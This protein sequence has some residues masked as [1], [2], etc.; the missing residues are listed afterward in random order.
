[1]QV[2][3]IVD[4]LLVPSNIQVSY[5][6]FGSVI[7]IFQI[8]PDIRLSGL[9][10]YI[11]EIIRINPDNIRISVNISMLYKSRYRYSRYKLSASHYI[12]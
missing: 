11:S 5:I 12:E 7:R 8:N 2:L 9:N 10:G 6:E 1:M 3:Q 4:L